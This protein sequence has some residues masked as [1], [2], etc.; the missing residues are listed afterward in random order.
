MVE[1][2]KIYPIADKAYQIAKSINKIVQLEVLISLS[3]FLRDNAKIWLGG[4]FKVI[5]VETDDSE[6]FVFAETN[7]FREVLL[8]E[9]PFEDAYYS[10]LKKN[11]S[12]KCCKE[13][14]AEE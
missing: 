9:S 12:I 10:G 2:Y 1:S 8:Y 14:T 5:L 3:Q 13:L 11:F 6:S 7:Y 4:S